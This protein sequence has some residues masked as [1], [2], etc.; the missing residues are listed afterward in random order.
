MPRFVQPS[1][2]QKYISEYFRKLSIIVK[3]FTWF[4]IASLSLCF[5]SESVQKQHEISLA[6]EMQILEQQR[7]HHVPRFALHRDSLPL[8]FSLSLSLSLCLSL[9]LSYSAPLRDVQ[10]YFH[11]GICCRGWRANINFIFTNRNY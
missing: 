6:L 11:F 3:S 5:S 2:K 8:S 1:I 10:R 7:I 4:C 9:S